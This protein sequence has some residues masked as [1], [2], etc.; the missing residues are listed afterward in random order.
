MTTVHKKVTFSETDTSL[1]PRPDK[2]IV[3]KIVPR[4][5]E[6]STAKEESTT[7]VASQNEEVCHPLEYVWSYS[8]KY[9]EPSNAYKKGQKGKQ[10]R[11]HV[12]VKAS[13]HDWLKEF[14]T[15]RDV[16]SIEMFWRIYNNS[17][18]PSKVKPGVTFSFFKKGIH[19]SWEDEN[20]KDGFSLVLYFNC[21]L[22]KPAQV[23]EYFMNCLLILV[24][25]YIKA[26]NDINGLSIDKKFSAYKL[27][28]WMKSKLN[29][30]TE[31]INEIYKA[32]NIDENNTEISINTI[33]HTTK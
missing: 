15:I 25:N 24:G 33:E 5:E 10:Q 28:F 7:D 16:D 2:K 21:K 4:K 30:S 18:P 29:Q 9:S 13:E 23:D 6:D 8:F 1:K 31:S 22:F 14:K 27:V 19:P 32:L 20:N 3:L 26:V 17:P 11:P 12:A